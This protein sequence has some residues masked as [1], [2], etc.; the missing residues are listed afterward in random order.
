M[1]A[2]YAALLLHKAGR[3][4][5]EEHINKVLEAAD[6][7]VEE[8]KVKSHVATLKDVDIDSE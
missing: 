6:S 4:V 7:K 5:D 8:S 2:I 1:E 3:R